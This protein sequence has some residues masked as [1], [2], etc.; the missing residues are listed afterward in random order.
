MRHRQTFCVLVW[1]SERPPHALSGLSSTL[2]LV[3][4][5]IVGIDLADTK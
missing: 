1:T 2:V 4:N 5:T 3:D